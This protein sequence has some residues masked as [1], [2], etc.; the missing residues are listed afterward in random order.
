M[1]VESF[2]ILRVRALSALSESLARTADSKAALE[3]SNKAV[4][5]A[6]SI[7]NT[8]P[9]ALIETLGE[10]AIDYW[11]AGD[12]KLAYQS[13]QEAV[14]RLLSAKANTKNWTK[15][16]MICGHVSGYFSMAAYSG[17]PPKPFADREPPERGIFLSS[18]PQIA[19]LYK[20]NRDWG[21]AGQLAHFAEAIGDVAEA[22]RWAHRAV[23]MGRGAM[24][25]EASVMVGMYGLPQAILDGRYKDA[26]ELAFAATAAH[27]ALATKPPS[28]R[29]S[30]T[31]DP[32][33]RVLAT[34]PK[35]I[36]DESEEYALL[37]GL[38]PSV[39]RAASF[40]ADNP[41]ALAAT[42]KELAI[43]CREHGPRTKAPGY[44]Q[45]AAE[46]L[47]ASFKDNADVQ[48]L[49][50]RGRVLLSQNKSGFFVICYIGMLSSLRAIDALTAYANLVPR[51]ERN[52]R[53]YGIY[54]RVIVPSV[55]TY[56]RARIER[57]PFH[58]R[59]PEFTL[60]QLR[61]AVVLPPETSV[62][63]VLRIVG[64][65]LGSVFSTEL[66]KWLKS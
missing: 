39:F 55:N 7:A 9:L 56:W 28:K 40:Q 12:R 32:F 58:F 48:D 26:L 38:I 30:E 36:I 13:F 51:L 16:F 24:G 47:E 37:M 11:Y 18:N 60:R 22:A 65:S 14:D 50:A 49:Q 54:R 43:A 41:A 57:S 19:D 8:L 31:D 15:M 10:N 64:D 52:L 3:P 46:V 5:L 35:S 20:P 53:M 63:R 29:P 17:K 61:E 2:P 34:A 44:W 1:D 59:L 21:I 42:I 4:E 45:E 66:I 25:E 6:R 62:K 33:E 27:V 23:Q